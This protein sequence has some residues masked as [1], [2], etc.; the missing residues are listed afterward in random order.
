M[1]ITAL[2]IGGTSVLILFGLMQISIGL[3][4]RMPMPVPPLKTLAV[5]VIAK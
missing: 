3:W 4:Y 2:G 5:S 1:L